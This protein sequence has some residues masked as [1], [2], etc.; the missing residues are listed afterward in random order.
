MKHSPCLRA[1]LCPPEATVALDTA[2]RTRE[3]TQAS[4]HLALQLCLRRP[5]LAQPGPTIASRASGIGNLTTPP[6]EQRTLHNVASGQSY[7][8]GISA[9]GCAAI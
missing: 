3:M 7:A 8:A 6:A 2:T 5:W 4:N 9:Q 1:E